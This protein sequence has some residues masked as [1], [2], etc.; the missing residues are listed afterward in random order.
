MQVHAEV[1]VEI[2]DRPRHHVAR[3]DELADLRGGRIVHPP[4][5]PEVLLLEQA[6]QLL[7]LHHAGPR[8]RREL[9]DDHRGHAPLQRVEVLLVLTVG[10]AVPDREHREARTGVRAPLGGQPA[11]AGRERDQGAE[12]DNRT[13]THW[14]RLLGQ[15]VRVTPSWA[16]RISAGR[17][18]AFAWRPAFG[19]LSS[20][21]AAPWSGSWWNNTSRVAPAFAS[22]AHP[23][24]NGYCPPSRYGS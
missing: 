4:R 10:A 1:A 13:R 20:I 17:P 12:G 16:A 5:G 14:L 18:F 7:A 19:S 22:H 11:R 6:L 3:A 21:P 23:S 2:D 15:R 9:G 8:V 24:P